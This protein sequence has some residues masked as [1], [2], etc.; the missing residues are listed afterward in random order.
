MGISNFF[1]FG[2]VTHGGGAS[3]STTLRDSTSRKLRSHRGRR[4]CHAAEDDAKAAGAE[5][6]ILGVV[7]ARPDAVES[8]RPT[9]ADTS[10]T[11][12]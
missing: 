10:Q 7:G 1:K 2:G 12:L 4:K 6:S 11:Y 3:N 5:L 9:A 8:R